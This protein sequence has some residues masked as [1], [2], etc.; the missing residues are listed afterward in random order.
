MLKIK[1]LIIKLLICVDFFGIF[2]SLGSDKFNQIYNVSIN[3][4][5]SYKI[6]EISG[7]KPKICISECSRMPLCESIVY[8]V[9]SRNCVLSSA[10]TAESELGTNNVTTRVYIK[11]S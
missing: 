7:L 6:K 3:E 4:F 10:R 9:F 2:Y 1:W 11:K 8:N 5:M